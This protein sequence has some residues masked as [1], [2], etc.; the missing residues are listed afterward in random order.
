MEFLFSEDFDKV[1]HN[2]RVGGGKE[3]HFPEIFLLNEYIGVNLFL[4]Q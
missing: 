4:A 3:A 2:G 1:M